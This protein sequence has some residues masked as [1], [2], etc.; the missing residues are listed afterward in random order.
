MRTLAIISV[1]LA[2]YAFGV[3]TANIRYKILDGQHMSVSCAN[4]ADPAIKGAAQYN[5]IVISCTDER[6]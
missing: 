4:G 6:K 3:A 1:L 2:G 5:T